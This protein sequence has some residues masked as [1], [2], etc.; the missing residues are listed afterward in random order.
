MAPCQPPRDRS[1][2]VTQQKSRARAFT[3]SALDK[4]EA[5]TTAPR[6]TFN[7]DFTPGFTKPDEAVIG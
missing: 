7:T 5:D 1:G 2:I 6:M 4:E 3:D